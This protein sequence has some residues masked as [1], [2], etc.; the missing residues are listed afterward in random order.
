M[1]PVPAD[2]TKM[3]L[4]DTDAPNGYSIA[5]FTWIIVYKEQNYDNRPKDK[6]TT[7]MKMLWWMVHDGQQYAEPL[8]YAQLPKGVV[9]KAEAIL[10]SVTYNGTPVLE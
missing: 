4:T 9:D 3:V 7:M 2:V 10:K 5:L 6:V 8:A 1:M